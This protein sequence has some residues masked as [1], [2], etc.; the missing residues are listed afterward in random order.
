MK[1]Y[2]IWQAC[3]L[4]A[5]SGAIQKEMLSL[6]RDKQMGAEDKLVAIKAMLVEQGRIEC[7]YRKAME[8]C[9]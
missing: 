1:D 5:A 7:D 4:K 9:E 6:L 2:F 3:A 8:Q